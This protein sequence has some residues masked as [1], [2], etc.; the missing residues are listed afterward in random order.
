L[1]PEESADFAKASKS[2][3]IGRVYIVSELTSAQRIKYICDNV[4][5]FIYVVSRLG[6]TGVAKEL[7]SSIPQ[8]ISNIRSITD[9]PLAVGFGISS[10]E[11][12]AEVAKAGADGVIIGSALVS[13]IETNFSRTDALPSILRK[14]VA[15]FKAATRLKC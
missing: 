13:V 5:S 10:P 1:P 15:S 12:V 8:T 14:K 11:H 9:K 2:C 7:S 6:A 4:D 3:G